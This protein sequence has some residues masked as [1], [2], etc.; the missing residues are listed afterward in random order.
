MRVIQ[1]LCLASVAAAVQ[2]PLLTK[3]SCSWQPLSS[4]ELTCH[5]DQDQQQAAPSS[6]TPKPA[7]PASKWEATGKCAGTYCIFKNPGFANGRGMVAITTSQNIKKLKALEK[8]TIGKAKT[9]SSPEQSPPPQF[10]IS[11]IPGKGLG[12]ISN[13]TLRRGD[14]IMRQSPAILLHR[15]FFEQIPPQIQASLLREAVSLLPPTLRKSFLGQM[16]HFPGDK[17]LSILATN[18]FQMDL[19]GAKDGHHYGNF[20]EVSRFNHDCR[21]NVA[22]RIDAKSLTHVTAAVRD[23]RPGEELSISYLDSM[24]PRAKRQERAKMA[25][26]FE[27]ACS[28]CSL[29]EKEAK[30]SDERL[31]EIKSIEGKLGDVTSGTKGV[32]KKMLERLVRLYREERLEGSMGGAYT[33]VAMNYNMLGD[34]KNAVKYAK[35]AAEAVELEM[36]EGQPDAEVMRELVKDAR[37]HFTWRGRIGMR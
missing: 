1:V 32:N 35:L 22:F 7:P 28:Q 36:G 23:V 20:P 34:A 8:A 5:L 11:Q 21:P 25:W 27:C 24:E 33:L 12:L 13:V 10:L 19:G 30:K 37:G 3:D 6:P 16:S 31:Q 4:V 26:G 14:T 29:P 2:K 17:I 18:S 9:K 15:T